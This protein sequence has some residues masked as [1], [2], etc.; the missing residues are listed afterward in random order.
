VNW[1]TSQGSTGETTPVE[2]IEVSDKELA[3]CV[4]CL[5]AEVHKKGE[6]VY[7][8][9][10]LYVVVHGI[11]QNLQTEGNTLSS[12]SSVL[13]LSAHPAIWRSVSGNSHLFWLWVVCITLLTF[14]A[15]AQRGLL[16][17]VCVSVCVCVSLF[18]STYSLPTGTK[19]AHQQYQRL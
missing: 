7:W 6:F 8:L 15:H 1:N 10:K 9:Q 13:I 3:Y 12:N 4:Q 5:A 14:G 17:L 11:Q 19:P 16:Y 18:V 2:V